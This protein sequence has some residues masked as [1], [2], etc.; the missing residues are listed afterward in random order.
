[1]LKKSAFAVALAVSGAFASIP[2]A[3]AEVIGFNGPFA[4]GNWTTTLNGDPAGGGAPAGVDT[5]GAPGSI[6]ITGGDGVCNTGPCTTDFTIAMP[7]GD[8]NLSFHWAYTTNDVDGSF[9]DVWG[10]LINGAFT[11][12]SVNDF[13]G[14]ET[15]S[16]DVALSGLAGTTFGFRMDCG[17][18][19]GGEAFAVVSQF[20]APEPASLALLGLGLAGLFATRRRF[21]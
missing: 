7:S 15:Q 9:F 21:A 18:C 3:N 11:Q 8:S 17:D 10:Y 12:L 5:S 16:G 13:A 2:I 19:F 6:K 1:M 4:A 14:P 20:K